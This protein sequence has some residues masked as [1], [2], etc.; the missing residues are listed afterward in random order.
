MLFLCSVPFFPP[1]SPLNVSRDGFSTMKE[2][3]NERYV[4][5]LWSNAICWNWWFFYIQQRYINTLNTSHDDAQQFSLISLFQDTHTH[6]KSENYTRKMFTILFCFKWNTSH[7]FQFCFDFK[8]V[9]ITISRVCMGVFVCVFFSLS[10]VWNVY[11]VALFSSGGTISLCRNFWLTS[12]PEWN[13]TK[14]KQR[15]SMS[16]TVSTIRDEHQ[17]EFCCSYCCCFY[18]KYTHQERNMQW[19]LKPNELSCW[20]RWWWKV[21]RNTTNEWREK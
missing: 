1:V 9:S 7:P 8:I 10:K 14:E 20:M 15:N 17:H 18:C 12:S 11:S 4:L 2:T 6:T 19:K 13:K 3:V 5:Y 21:K 16:L